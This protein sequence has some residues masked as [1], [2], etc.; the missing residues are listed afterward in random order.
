MNWLKKHWLLILI[1]IL[2]LSLRLYRI[3]Y[4]MTFLEDE[5][6]DLLMV[7]RM[8]D[9]GRPVLL[10]PQTSTGDMYLGPLYYYLIAPSLYLSQMDPIGPAVLIA[11]SGVLTTGILF[12]LGKKWFSSTA[13]Y[14]AALMFGVLPLSVAVTRASWNPNLVPLVTVL[15]L[16]VYDRLTMG[17]AKLIHWLSYG[18]LIGTMVQL[19][20]MALIFCGVLSIA[21]AWSYREHVRVLLKGILVS[22]VGALIMLAPFVV[23]ELRN[24]WVNTQALI[25]FIAPAE[26][27][28]IRYDPPL[29]LWWSKV[30][31]TSNR[32]VSSTFVGTGTNKPIALFIVASFVAIVLLALY[33][34]PPRTYATVTGVLVACLITL[35]VYQE[36]IHLHYL[37]FA[38]PLIILALTGALHTHSPRWLKGSASLLITATLLLG[39]PHTLG[40]ITSDPTHQVGK[41]RDVAN[42]IVE[43]A[44]G[45]PYNVVST[46]GMYT[47]PF[48]YFLAI[49]DHPPSNEQASRIFDICAGSP[50][51]ENDVT[52]TLLFLT[53]PGHP[54]IANYLGHPQLNSFEGRR[55]MIS[56][57]H[58]SY[59]LWVAEIVLE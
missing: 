41:A 1:L 37:E 59:G 18:A 20:Y 9:T 11:L 19:H 30:G 32:L 2:A 38:I 39:V 51:P 42:Y 23:F 35:G 21:L 3:D 56:N 36:N 5:G 57:D 44:A 12:Y 46:E 45:K 58:V 53:G 6:R 22:L 29:S 26:G 33:K 16:V 55:R 25:K 13:G 4:T 43:R 47:T 48:Q 10:G 52:T 7:K 54:S 24:D 27:K 31:D 34:K 17:R 14:F 49:S 50:C 8:F 28:N 40:A 15:M